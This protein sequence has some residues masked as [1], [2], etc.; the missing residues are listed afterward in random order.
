M[1][2]SVSI[3]ILEDTPPFKLEAANTKLYGVTSDEILILIL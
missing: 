2:L 1:N 3:F